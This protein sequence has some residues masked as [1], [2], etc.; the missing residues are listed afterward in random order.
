MSTY[1]NYKLHEMHSQ[2]G[3]WDGGLRI[4]RRD[5]S[6]SARIRIDH[7]HSFLWKKEDPPQCINC[8]CRLTVKH[9]LFDCV[10]FIKT[11]NKHFNEN[12]FKDLFEKNSPYSM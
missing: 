9:I 11:R 12:S 8:N 5:E 3:L 4:T 10:D 2:L 7:F 6:V 1:L